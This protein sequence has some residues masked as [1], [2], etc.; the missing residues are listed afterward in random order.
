MKKIMMILFAAVIL[1]S[2]AGCKEKVQEVALDEPSLDEVV[3]A[4]PIDVANH[5]FELTSVTQ[6]GSQ[7]DKKLGDTISF[8]EDTCTIGKLSGEYKQKKSTVNVTLKAGKT[9]QNIV[10]QVEGQTLLSE[11]SVVA[12]NGESVV[13]VKTYTMKE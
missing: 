5:T 3:A 8:T 1:F 9:E 7:V 13:E 6:D 10:F 2:F 12:D 4:E 11:D